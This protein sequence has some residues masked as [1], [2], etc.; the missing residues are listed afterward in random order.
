MYTISNLGSLFYYFGALIAVIFLLLV[1]RPCAH[2]NKWISKGYSYIEGLVFFNVILRLIL[3]GYVM[4]VI[5]AFLNYNYMDW[6]NFDLRF[7]S[8]LTIILLCISFLFPF[9]VLALLLIFRK[10]MEEPHIEKRIGSL[11]ENID[12]ERKAAILFSFFFL[13]RRLVFILSIFFL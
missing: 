7:S 13:M 8:A 5:C 3:E 6:S 2:K 10:R 11:Y 1:I 4:I 12:P 9:F